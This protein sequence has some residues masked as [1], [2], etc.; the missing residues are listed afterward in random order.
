MAVQLI[1]KNSSVEDKR[2]TTNQLA[3]GEISLNYNEAGAFL[4]CR[5]STGAIQQVGGVKIS[6]TAPEDPA[7]QT[8]WFEP[9]SLTLFIFDGTNWLPIAGGGGSGGG[10]DESGGA[11]GRGRGER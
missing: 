9:A 4:C 7:K 5:D 8:Q 10:G 11:D 1:L 3:N 2:P 6:A